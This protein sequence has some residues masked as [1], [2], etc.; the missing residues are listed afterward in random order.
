M[1]DE[2]ETNNDWLLQPPRPG[3]V[4]IHVA[5]GEEIEVSPEVRERIEELMASLVQSEVSGF[6]VKCPMF[7]NCHGYSCNLATCVPLSNNCVA[8]FTCRVA[9]FTGA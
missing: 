8:D 6:A 3:E 9:D 7:D 1:T 5:V 4:H 2:A